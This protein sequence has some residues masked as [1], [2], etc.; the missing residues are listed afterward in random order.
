MRLKFRGGDAARSTS[1]LSWRSH[2]WYVIGMRVVCTPSSQ[3]E[4]H[5]RR[6]P[7]GPSP[8]ATAATIVPRRY[9]FS[10]RSPAPAF[11]TR[12]DA[13][14][15]WRSERWTQRPA[16]PRA[17]GGHGTSARVVWH[18]PPRTETQHLL[19]HRAY[20]ASWGAALGCRSAAHIDAARAS[21]RFVLT[22]P[23]PTATV[24][25]LVVEV[26]GSCGV[27]TRRALPPQAVGSHV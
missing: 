17:R 4:A 8:A 25:R 5:A 13:A 20:G 7:Y 15:D 22:N 10:C 23:G 3:A 21:S 14:R 16:F 26:R 1:Q 18:A 24:G 27:R 11:E 6:G 9:L 2:V 12:R 19:P